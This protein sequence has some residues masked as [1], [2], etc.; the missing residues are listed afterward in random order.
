MT[1][2]N[3]NMQSNIAAIAVIFLSASVLAAEQA[4]PAKVRAGQFA[5]AIGEQGL[6]GELQRPDGKVLPAMAGTAEVRY[7]TLRRP[8][9][10]PASV[11][12]ATDMVSVE[13]KLPGEPEIH[14]NVTYR[15]QA[16]RDV[17]VLVREVEV[18]ASAKLKEDLAVAL[19]NWPGPLPANTWL[20]LSNGMTGKLGEKAAGYNFQ[21]PLPADYT[22]LPCP[23]VTYQDADGQRVT[24]ASDPY[25]STL[26]TTDHLEWTYPKSIGLEDAVEKRRLVTVI[27]GGTPE[28]ALNAFFQYALPE[29]PPGPQWLHEIALVD[30]D[31]MSDAGQGWF[32]DIDALAA[33]LP[34][35]ERSKVF[36]CLHG[37]YDWCGRYSFDAKTGKFD[38]QWTA[39][40]NVERHK[41]V[42]GTFDVGGEKLDGSFAK[43][44]PV[45][46]TPQSLRGRLVY[47][48]S[49]GFRVGLY[50]A[51]GLNAGTE[52]PGFHQ[53][54]V[55]KPGGWIGP[56]TTGKS[57]CMN[58]STPEVRDFFLRYAE[59]L[60][61]Q[62][63][64]VIDALVWD[65]TD[66]IPGN[67]Y[68]SAEVPGYASRAMMRLVR[69]IARQAET[70]DPPVAFLI[71]DCPGVRGTSN[72]A[73]MAHGTYQDTWCDPIAWRYGIFPNWR[74][75][76]WSCCWWPVHKWKW[77][78]FGVRHYQA[79]VSISNGFG[80]NTGF[81]EMSPEM[82][83][84][85]LDLFHWRAQ[86]RAQMK[87]MESLPVYE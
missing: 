34:A 67:S 57:Y 55:L 53:R 20:P 9:N 56:D 19:P 69:Q 2:G 52:L 25:F 41:D 86:F 70:H 7:G 79:P 80:D 44:S 16:E 61:R 60:L 83:K 28:D 72:Y 10:Q 74:N 77:V 68:G 51:D 78:E 15:L 58:P 62:Y 37:W 23:F 36:L 54:L 33:A 38:E 63:G 40:G 12:R 47:A 31:Y 21:G 42:Y 32:K 13:Y 18:R 5:V 1:G 11:N 71:S 65:E 8:L 81:S 75:T 73:L 59:A 26:F 49:R 82:Q 39:F 46:M 29:I 24:V 50:F 85:V 22:R 30:Y 64:D 17:V 66:M 3:K 76:R 45:A 35:G 14:V 27:H 84:K 6:A 43:C 48:K 87:V 4:P